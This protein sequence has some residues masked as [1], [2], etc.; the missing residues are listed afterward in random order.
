M[1]YIRLVFTIFKDAATTILLAA[2]LSKM[3]EKGDTSRLLRIAWIV[4]L[5]LI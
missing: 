2:T 1:D 3:T 5:L 4:V